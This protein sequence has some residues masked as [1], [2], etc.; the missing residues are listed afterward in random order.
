MGLE[1]VP[2]PPLASISSIC[3]YFG[4]FFGVFFCFSW[5]KGDIEKVVL[6]AFKVTS[7]HAYKFVQR[8]GDA[9]TKH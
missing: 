4:P 1:G 9:I 5:K 8:V 3:K 2:A 7:E 6:D